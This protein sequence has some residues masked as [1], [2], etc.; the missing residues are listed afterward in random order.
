MAKGLPL[1]GSEKKFTHRLWSSRR[2]VGNNNC[3]AYAF[4]D[5]EAAARPHKSIPGDC[6][7]LSSRTRTRTVATWR[8]AS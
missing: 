1:S 3:Y 5:Y 4:S 6:S 2:G 8:G 7:G